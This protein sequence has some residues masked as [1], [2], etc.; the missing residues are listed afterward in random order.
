[1]FSAENW[2]FWNRSSILIETTFKLVWN[3]TLPSAMLTML[4]VAEFVRIFN[5]GLLLTAIHRSVSLYVLRSIERSKKARRCDIRSSLQN[6]AILSPTYW[7]A[8]YK[9]KGIQ[10]IAALKISSC[11]RV[12]KIIAIEGRIFQYHMK[13]FSYKNRAFYLKI[14]MVSYHTKIGDAYSYH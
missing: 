14:E 6:S 12:L 11:R 1:M 5:S 13:M 4:R 3:Y 2:Q 7:V 9:L 10:N 8:P